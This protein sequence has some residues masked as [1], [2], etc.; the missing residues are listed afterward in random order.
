MRADVIFKEKFRSFALLKVDLFI[1]WIRG[2]H[3]SSACFMRIVSNIQ[4]T[5]A[6]IAYRSY[7]IPQ[8]C[9]DQHALQAKPCLRQL[10]G[11]S[12]YRSASR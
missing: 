4:K 8:F 11:P 5:G 12:E 7:T 2:H 3:D 9:A 10:G 1:N 6:D